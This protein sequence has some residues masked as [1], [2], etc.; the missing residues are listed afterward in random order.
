MRYDLSF[1]NKQVHLTNCNAKHT[2]FSLYIDAS[3]LFYNL[4]LG[5]GTTSENSK[6]S[7]KAKAEGCSTSTEDTIQGARGVIQ[8]NV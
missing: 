3:F 2:V 4:F 5:T 1:L 7:T 8:T 6:G